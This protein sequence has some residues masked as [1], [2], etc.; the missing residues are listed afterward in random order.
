MEEI[1]ARA[2]IVASVIYDHFSSKHDL[3]VRLLEVHGRALIE[4]SVRDVAHAAP[5]ERLRLSL[6][7]FYGFV[8]EDPFVWRFLFRDPPAD[9]RIARVYDR[10]RGEATD[11]IASVIGTEMTEAVADTGM[12]RDRAA[13]MLAEGARA[14]TDG[15]AGWWY[16]HREVPREQVVALA[17]SL[18]WSGFG[19]LVAAQRD[20]A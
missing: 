8:E 14:A 11:A 18:L 10:I 16:E 6:E 9:P 20:G 4:R 19:G 12:P 5:R 3:Y 17:T 2:G 1:A 13:R 15:L 7:A